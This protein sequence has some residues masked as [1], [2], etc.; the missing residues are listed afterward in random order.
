MTRSYTTLTDVTKGA[1]LRAAPHVAAPMNFGGRPNHRGQLRRRTGRA[2][3]ASRAA[4]AR[5]DDA[6][7]ALG[8]APAPCVCGAARP[9]ASWSPRKRWE[10]SSHRQ[11]VGALLT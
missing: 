5:V 1:A 10:Q 6:R 7:L 2:A 4:P 8:E 9:Q 3:T 11:H